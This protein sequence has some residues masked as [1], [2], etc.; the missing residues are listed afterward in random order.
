VA[1]WRKLAERYADEPVIGAYDLINELNWDF[2][3]SGGGHGCEE[4]NATLRSLMREGRDGGPA[5]HGRDQHPGAEGRGLRG[6]PGEGR[7]GPTAS[8]ITLP[9][10]HLRE[11]AVRIAFAGPFRAGDGLCVDG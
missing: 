7:R 9:K 11:V 5:V 4:T 1:L 8:L 6:V 10:L 3:K 2:E